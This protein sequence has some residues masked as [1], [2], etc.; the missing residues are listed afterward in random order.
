M[1]MQH[2]MREHKGQIER[3]GKM[4]QV[5]A[6]T[7][8]LST[9][10]TGITYFAFRSTVNPNAIDPRILLPSYSFEFWLALPQIFAARASVSASAPSA[11][12]RTPTSTC[13]TLTCTDTS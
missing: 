4:S 9:R 7:V 11:L 2:R 10:P 1:M 8:D 13:C 5:T 12:T 3:P 6:I